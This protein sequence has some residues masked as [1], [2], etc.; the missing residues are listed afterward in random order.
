[1]DAS[2]KAG[3][4]GCSWLGDS[5]LGGVGGSS[6]SDSGDA[7]GGS[8]SV[9]GDAGWRSFFCLAFSSPICWGA[10]SSSRDPC[11]GVVLTGD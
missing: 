4:A 3:E 1:M 8:F 6:I 9:A 7:G 5:V 2:E 10:V 11:C